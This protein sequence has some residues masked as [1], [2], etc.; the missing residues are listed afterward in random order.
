[1]ALCAMFCLVS[2]WAREMGPAKRTTENV[3]FSQRLKARSELW[4]PMR[5]KQIEASVC[6]VGGKPRRPVEDERINSSRTAV[7]RRAGGAHWTNFGLLEPAPLVWG[8]SLTPFR[9]SRL[10]STW[11][12]RSPKA[13]TSKSRRSS[14]SSSFLS[15]PTVRKSRWG[16]LWPPTTCKAA[17][18]GSSDRHG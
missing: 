17:E 1:M 12:S 3:S 15:A 14:G 6:M 8:P 11:I 2:V 18:T 13:H 10:P 9:H 4:Y 5:G 16:I 7:L